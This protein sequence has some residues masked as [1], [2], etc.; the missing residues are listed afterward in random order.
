MNAAKSIIE[1][2]KKE[3]CRQITFHLNPDTGMSA[4]FVIDSV[5]KDSSS[6]VSGGTRFAHIDEDETLKDC[7]KL[8]RA[9]TRKSNVLGVNDGGAKAIVLANKPKTKEFLESVGDF[10]QLQ[11]GL[12][13]TAIDLGFN[14][15]EAEVIASRTKFIDSLSHNIGGLGS[16]GENTAEG[17]IHCFKVI[18]EKLLNK[19][20]EQCKISIQGLGSVGMALAKR[21]VNL[22]CK[23]I[24]SDTDKNKCDEAEK[25]GIN[26]ILPQKILS[27]EVDILSPCAF[28]SVITFNNI[29][30]LKCKVIA[31]GANNILED[32][33]LD[34]EL[35][36][37]G[38]TFVPDFVINCAGF[39]QA[40]IERNKGDVEEA[41]EKSMIAADKLNQVIEFSRKN[42][43]TLLQSSLKLFGGK[44]W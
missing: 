35:N 29:K 38:I 44:K 8:A 13:R 42:N 31:G 34:K 7:I 25:L 12:F 32:E 18:S 19:R 28:G 21:L 40:L 22:G 17:M 39:L 37:L 14:L 33:S 24:A 36:N 27:E 6:V 23:V 5:P 9:M 26:T 43:C 41:R 4:I 2:M 3:K 16:T 10:I 11:N 30:E 15:N 1:L 20:I